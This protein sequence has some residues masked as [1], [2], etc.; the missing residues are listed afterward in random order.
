MDAAIAEVEGEDAPGLQRYVKP[1]VAPTSHAHTHTHEHI[2]SKKSTDSIVFYILGV[3]PVFISF[4]S[5]FCLSLRPFIFCGA[6]VANS[7]GWM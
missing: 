2:D 4:E 7:S 3:F 6:V 5:E 1:P